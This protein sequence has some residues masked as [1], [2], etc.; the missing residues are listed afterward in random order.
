MSEIKDK[1][2]VALDVDSLD[3]A[4]EFVDK[5]YPTVKLFK[6]GSQLF[7]AHG[8]KLVKKVGKKGAKV[9]LDLKFYDILI[10][11]RTPAM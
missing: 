2:I 9:F 7:T 4:K 5:L 1:L 6:I 10:L 11:S 3:K 8:P